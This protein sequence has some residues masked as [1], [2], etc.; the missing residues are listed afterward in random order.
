MN[1][2]LAEFG[3]RSNQV[4]ERKTELDQAAENLQQ[5]EKRVRADI[6]KDICKVRLAETGLQAA[7][8]SLTARVEMRRITANQIEAKTAN[9]S[10]LKE[11]E[12][13]LAEA[14]AGI[15]EASDGA[16]QCTRGAR[17]ADGP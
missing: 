11:A 8:Q 7:R 9:I 12:A 16:K 2:T 6:E 3:K 5:V 4:R 1:W 10:A 15:Y 17:A 14:E 13:Q